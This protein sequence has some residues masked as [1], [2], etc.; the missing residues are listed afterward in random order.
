MAKLSVVISAYN[1]EK[2]I[3]D[4]LE[5]VK[6]ADEIIFVDN[7]SQDKTLEIAKKYTSKTF[8]RP[9]NLMLNINKNFGFEKT[10]GDWILS[11]DADERVEPELRRE[12]EYLLRQ[13][14]GGRAGITGY[15]IPR[16]NIIF[17]KWIQYTGWYPDYQSRLFRRGKG[18][19]DEKHV[20]EQLTV[21]G[22][23]GT[24][25]GHILHSNYESTSQFLYK[26]TQ[27][28]V[29]NEAKNIAE[30]GK[31]VAW[32][33][34]I[35]FPAQEFLRRF[36]AN[37]GWKDG[38]HGLVLSLL[39]AFYHLLVFTQV[40]E[41]QGFWESEERGFCDG[42]MDEF[43]KTRRE[44]SYWMVESEIKDTKNPF[45]KISLKL[46]KKIS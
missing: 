27:I 40:W 23:V 8:I 12:I 25:K 37:E 34:A 29:P 3:K 2:N 21:S 11:L 6:W 43:K 5:S 35:R 15:K 44:F 18:R 32:Q 24:L 9:N 31:R 17:G 10:L 33:D 38:L 19:F 41:K 16:K 14:Y 46:K 30:S 39:M 42:V 45:K 22:E 13:D 26:M 4:C 1:E 20:H 7:T 28:Y 36:F